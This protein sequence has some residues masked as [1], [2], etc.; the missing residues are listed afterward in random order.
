MTLG[1]SSTIIDFVQPIIVQV[2]RFVSN[3]ALRY[4]DVPL[5]CATVVQMITRLRQG[6][7]LWAGWEKNSEASGSLRW[8]PKCLRDAKLDK[9]VDYEVVDEGSLFGTNDVNYKSG[10]SLLLWKK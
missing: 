5:R 8:M 2:D 10:K 3:G 1:I 9:A 6:G 4:L 7:T